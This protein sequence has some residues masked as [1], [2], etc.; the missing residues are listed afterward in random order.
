MRIELKPHHKNVYPLNGYVIRGDQ[1]GLWLKDIERLVRSIREVDTYPIP[2][3]HPN[4]VWG[5]LVVP[6]LNA[7]IFET[8]LLRYQVIKERIFLPQYA[9]LFPELTLEELDR[10]FPDD[11]Y[12]IHPEVGFASLEES[13]NWVV[14][15]EAEV[16]SIITNR[17]PKGVY[18]PQEVHGFSIRERDPEELLKVLEKEVFPEKESFEDRP[19]SFFEQIKRRL[20]KPFFKEETEDQANPSRSTGGYLPAFL[21]KWKNRI[22]KHYKDLEDRN[23]KEI[24]KLLNMMNKDPE[25]G[26]KYA[27][28]LDDSGASRS[29]EEVPY[30]MSK[31]RSDFSLFGKNRRTGGGGGSV[32]FSDDQYQS[33]RQKY[34]Q[35]AWDLIQK[36]DHQKAAFVYL[37]LLKDY[38]TAAQT[39]EKGGHYEEGASVYLKYLDDKENA[40]RCYEKGH[41]YGKAI[42]LYEALEKFEKAGDLFIELGKREA[43]MASYERVVHKDLGLHQ[44]EKAAT[45]LRSKMGETARS[46]STLLEGWKE[47]RDAFKCLDSYLT[48]SEAEDKLFPLL[49]Q[50]YQEEISDHKKKT[51]LKV[52]IR[53]YQRRRSTRDKVRDLSY[54]IIASLHKEDPDIL[55]ELKSLNMEDSIILK[56]ILRY[57]QEKRK[58]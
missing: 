33:L 44:Y 5:C 49:S 37:K 27:I 11:I 2:G 23:Q 20:L 14:L 30:Q 51:F 35:T 31:M 52:L 10:F 4:T 57:K 42:P 40:A 39:L 6:R 29:E 12:F 26:L 18:I 32:Q 58:R 50:L 56:D 54:E 45:L 43:A 1:P 25:E 47:G 46:Q 24:D 53:E 19:L 17:P 55:S 22:Q 8:N 38:R 9:T 15:L 34:N 16:T 48:N 7:E 28:P 21:A 13:V 41:M 3:L 36:G